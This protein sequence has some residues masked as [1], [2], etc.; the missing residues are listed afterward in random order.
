MELTKFA[1]KAD[2]TLPELAERISEA[3]GMKWET[4]WNEATF[5]PGSQFFLLQEEW[6][7]FGGWV[8]I[9]VAAKLRSNGH[10]Y[11]V[12]SKSVIFSRTNT[13]DEDVAREARK[14]LHARLE[15][16]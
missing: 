9:V 3:T 5:A 15:G 12:T 10:N 4:L 7:D 8:V 14:E 11:F 13:Q 1:I 16:V 6:E 2:E